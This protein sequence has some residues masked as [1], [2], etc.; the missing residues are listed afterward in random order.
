MTRHGK[1]VVACFIALLIV[2]AHAGEACAHASLVK[3]SPADGAVVPV[4]PAALSLTFNEPVSPLVIRLIG[5][6]GAPIVPRRSLA[7]TTRSRSPHLPTCSA[8]RMC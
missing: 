6:D 4:A 7:K 2:V 5:P 8:A 3:A 1:S